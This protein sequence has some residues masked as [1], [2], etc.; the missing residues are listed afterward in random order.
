MPLPEDGTHECSVCKTLLQA[1]DVASGCWKCGGRVVERW[2]PMEI[3]SE[4]VEEEKPVVYDLFKGVGR[5]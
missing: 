1:E 4:P 3:V 2:I 5:E